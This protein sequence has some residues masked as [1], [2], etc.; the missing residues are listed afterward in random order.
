MEYE[1]NRKHSEPWQRGR[2]GSFC[3]GEVRGLAEEL[4]NGSELMVSIGELTICSFLQPWRFGDRSD[5][6]SG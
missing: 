5:Q 2:R 4:L 6:D 3:P 1:S